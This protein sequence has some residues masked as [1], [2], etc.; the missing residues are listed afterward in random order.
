MDQLNL[1]TYFNCEV[2]EPKIILGVNK[3]D[4]S[5]LPEDPYRVDGKGQPYSAIQQNKYFVHKTGGYHF[6][7]EKKIGKND[8]P[9]ITLEKDYKVKL[10][11]PH[12][13]WSDPYPKIG[14]SINKDDQTQATM[15]IKMHRIVSYAFIKAHKDPKS[16]LVD[17]I[18]GDITNYKLNNLRWAD[19]SK[20][21]K[22]RKF[23]KS[24][25]MELADFLK[26]G[27]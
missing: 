14:V 23:N 18:D 17:H 25:Q 13:S 21:L 24:K 11:K 9:Y 27:R 1:F 5:T 4:L 26:K 19:A 22:G 2:D 7:D 12:V 10:I 6:T 16:F 15:I 3:V 20:N 8:Y